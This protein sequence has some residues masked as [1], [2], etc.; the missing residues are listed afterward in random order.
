[1]IKSTSNKNTQENT[2][3]NF[4]R[5]NLY[6]TKTNSKILKEVKEKE[7][8]QRTIKVNLKIKESNAPTTNRIN[9]P[10]SRMP[11]TPHGNKKV[12]L[13]NAKDNSPQKIKLK[14]SLKIETCETFK[15]CTTIPN[16]AE[17]NPYSTKNIK[18]RLDRTISFGNINEKVKL[19]S[20]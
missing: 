18:K 3:L 11:L 1:M 9:T 19:I 2:H 15:V 4:L 16:Q 8:S 17:S 20:Y 13:P 5:T 12:E 14:K 10:L 7:K 6:K